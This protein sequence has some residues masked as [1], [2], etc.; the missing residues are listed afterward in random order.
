MR[1]M[2]IQGQNFKIID[3]FDSPITVPDCIVVAKNK[4]GTAHGEAKLY[5]SSKDK[6][7][8]FY[9]GTGFNAKCFILKK[10]LI[11]YMIA[12]KSE[13]LNPSQN[14]RGR[15]N[16]P[17]LWEKRMESIMSLD[18]VIEF[19]IH[20]QV[21]IEGARGYVNSED[22]GYN[23]IRELSLPLVSYISAME[24]VDSSGHHV[25]YW[26]LFA[27]F[28]AI[29]DKSTALVFRYGKKDDANKI[30]QQN[31]RKENELQQARI[32]QGRYREKL[33]EECPFCPITMINDERLLIASHIKPWAVAN[34]KEKIDP[35][36]GF[37]LSP[38]Y[39]KLFD[40]G[41]ITFTD[42]RRVLVSNWLSPRN[43]KRIGLKNN[44]FFQMLP[45]DE[46][47]KKYLEYHRE[48]VFKG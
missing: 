19:N 7:R 42:E 21:Q 23:I 48:L 38:L 6:M 24:L 1:I 46:F 15:E 29:V 34:N 36:N 41:F 40:R 11:A 13:Y 4:L 28:D 2:E 12:M 8:D 33:L 10:D 27:D 44:D 9:G 30:K 32:G 18:D 5:I 22:E 16:F 43:Q 20:D 3:T 39:D 35:K 45:I 31:A 47:R 25:Y 37:I 14:Y 26:K 17:E